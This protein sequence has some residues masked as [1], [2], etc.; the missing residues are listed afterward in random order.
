MRS[1]RAHA[2]TELEKGIIWRIAVVAW[3]ARNGMRL[4]GDLVEC[5][6]YKGTTARIVAEYV[7][8]KDEPD[9][10]YYLNDLFEHDP[11]MPHHPMPEHGDKLYDE[12][13]GRFADMRNVVVTRGRVPDS[14]SEAAPEKIAFLT[15]TSTMQTLRSARSK[16][17][18]IG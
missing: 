8:L 10:K 13:R 18:S 11:A 1:F 14:F 5:A 6:C 2:S 7:G 9:R 3:A 16:F 15:S 12:V 17:S 4:K